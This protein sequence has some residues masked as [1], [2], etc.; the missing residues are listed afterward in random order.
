MGDSVLDFVDSHRDLKVVIDKLLKFHCHVRDL[1]RRA[2]GLAN[3][4]LR[5]TVNRRPDF[6][7]TLFSSHIRPYWITVHASGTLVLGLIW[8]C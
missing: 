4:L 3:S 7:V 2:A 1:M 8:L 5:S 6:M